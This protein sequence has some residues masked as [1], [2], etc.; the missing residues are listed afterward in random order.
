MKRVILVLTVG[1]SLLALTATVAM[2][3]TIH[4]RG[5]DCFGTNN[6]DSMYG[7]SRH[8]AIFAKAGGDFVTGRGGADDLNGQD[9]DDRVLGGPGDDWVKG[10][11]QNDTVKGDNGNDTITGGSGDNVI[12]AGDGMKDLIV[13]GAGSK[14]VIYYDPGLDRFSNCRFDQ[15]PQNSSG[16]GSPASITGWGPSQEGSGP[17]GSADSIR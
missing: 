10:G 2:A 12:R 14:N 17:E 8:D 9:G 15:N 6:G 11:N 7:T 16:G 13:C 1:A 4:C 5:G 3:A